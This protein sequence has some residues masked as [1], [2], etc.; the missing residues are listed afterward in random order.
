MDSNFKEIKKCELKII[1][2]LNLDFKNKLTLST[3]QQEVCKRFTVIERRKYAPKSFLII[4]L[5]YIQNRGVYRVIGTETYKMRYRRTIDII[6]EFGYKIETVKIR[7]NY[8]FQVI[9]LY[10]YENLCPKCRGSGTQLSV[11]PR[12]RKAGIW[13]Y[14][15]LCIGDGK[16][17][18]IETIKNQRIIL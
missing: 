3:I 2:N 11:F 10:D 12:Y 16:L 4:L 7:S 15:D 13:E 1:R 14:C 8:L 6:S 17:T 18:W 5:N 9:N